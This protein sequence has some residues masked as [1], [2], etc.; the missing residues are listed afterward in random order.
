[1]LNKKGNV[2]QL[3]RMALGILLI[4]KKYGFNDEEFVMQ[5]QENSYLQSFS[6]VK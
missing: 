5:I 3:L 4:Q 2:V 6:F 1:M